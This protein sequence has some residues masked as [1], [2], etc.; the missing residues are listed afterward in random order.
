MNKMFYKFPV[1]RTIDDVLPHIKDRDEFIVAERDFG[2]VINYVVAMQNTFDMAGPDDIGGAIRRE[3]RGLIF[4]KEGKIMSRPFHKF[5]NVN[6]REETQMHLIDMSNPHVIMEK[7]DGSMI[8]AIWDAND[9]V[10]L[11]TKMGITDIANSVESWLMSEN[12]YSPCEW[13]LAQNGLADIEKFEYLRTSLIAGV[14]H[15]F[16]WISPSN[17]IVINYGKSDLVY[18]GSRVNETGE[19]FFDEDTPFTRV[20]RYGHVDGS[21]DEYVA[22]QRKAE[23]R[24]GDIIRFLSGQMLKVKNDWYVRIHKTKDMI[25]TERH[26]ANIIV[27]EELD[28]V[29]PM[30]DEVDIKVVRDYE[31]RF[32]AALE[33]VL[34]R[35][36]GLVLLAKTLYG[37]DKKQVA[38]NFVPMLKY[39]EDSSF[40]FSALDGKDIREIVI[41]KIK[42]SV[43]NTTKYD[44]LMKWMEA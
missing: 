37:G 44:A 41:K 40:I 12:G 19:Y 9:N 31:V 25:R 27:N 11:A 35:L 42:A 4:D 38:I 22:R 16:E 17:K 23:D 18:L 7:M 21:L 20:V 14:T 29:L 6:E 24:E 36:E 10:R 1:I 39:K 43:G 2:V 30:L 8:R 32:D 28:D 34:A 15:L 3:C 13:D 5:F 26:I 33:N